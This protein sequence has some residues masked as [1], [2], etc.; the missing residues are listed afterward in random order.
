MNC[1]RDLYAQAVQDSDDPN[2]KLNFKKVSVGS[3]MTGRLFF[4]AKR[5]ILRGEILTYDY[6]RVQARN[7]LDFPFL[8]SS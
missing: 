3:T 5:P 7:S 4:V 6:G 8:A 1:S 2:L